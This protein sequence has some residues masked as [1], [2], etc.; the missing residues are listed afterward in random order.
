MKLRYLI[1]AVKVHSNYLADIL[2]IEKTSGGS[3]RERMKCD[4]NHVIIGT[5]RHNFNNLSFIAILRTTVYA[6]SML[7]SC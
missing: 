3:V 6:E 2:R 4:I 5:V 1:V 7:R